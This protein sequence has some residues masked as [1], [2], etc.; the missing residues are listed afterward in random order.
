MEVAIALED[1][2]LI[3]CVCLAMRR[4]GSVLGVKMF[5]SLARFRLLASDS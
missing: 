4:P 1:K 3:E 2:E 5:H